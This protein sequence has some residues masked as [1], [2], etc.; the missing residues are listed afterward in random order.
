MSI[1]DTSAVSQRRIQTHSAGGDAAC[2][3]SLDSNPQ[4][5]HI[6][7]AHVRVQE[8]VIYFSSCTP[9]PV[10]LAHRK[11]YGLKWTIN[12]KEHRK[13][14]AGSTAYECTKIAYSSQQSDCVHNVFQSGFQVFSLRS[15]FNETL[16]VVSH[17]LHFKVTTV[18]S[19]TTAFKC[20]INDA[21]SGAC[22][23]LHLQTT[24][25]GKNKRSCSTSGLCQAYYSWI[26]IFMLCT[27][28]FVFWDMLR[29]F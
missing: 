19:D 26:Y 25:H 12:K 24:S 11:C 22:L 6:Y 29:K 23:H 13:W 15:R 17:V 8:H 27:I 16:N 18:D 10:V 21:T 4:S 20:C 2:G 28:R 3:K 1:S 5:Q 14:A 9:Q 7:W